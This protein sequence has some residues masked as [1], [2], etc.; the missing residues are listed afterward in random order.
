MM[1]SLNQKPLR[2]IPSDTTH[3][4]EAD[5]EIEKIICNVEK[6]YFNDTADQMRYYL[7]VNGGNVCAHY[8]VIT[9]TFTSSCAEAQANALRPGDHDVE[10]HGSP[11]ARSCPRNSV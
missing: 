10:L 11:G 2:L 5:H 9:E 4:L 1:L 3:M 7:A 8:E 6:F